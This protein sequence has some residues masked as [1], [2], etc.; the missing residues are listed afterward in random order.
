ME[1][2]RVLVENING[3]RW[4]KV[5]NDNGTSA[6][7]TQTTSGE[8]NALEP[9][10]SVQQA[11]TGIILTGTVATQEE[12]DAMVVGAERVFGSPVDNQLVVNPEADDQPW[13]TD[14]TYALGATPPIS[15]GTLEAN[16]QSITITGEVAT[17]DDA[18]LVDSAMGTISIPVTNGITVSSGEAPVATDLTDAELA[19]VNNTSV[20][21]AMKAYEL[22]NTAKQQLDS[23]VPLLLKTD[24]TL[25]VRG[26]LSDPHKPENQD[27]DSKARAQSVADYLISKGVPASRII[28]EGR[29]VA[30]PIASNNTAEGRAANQRA[31]LAL[32]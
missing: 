4:A 25:T 32:S 28:V 8:E 24:K 30:D 23:I 12:A 6:D 7:P 16:S 3:V 29:G 17:D 19:Q 20:S 1:R 5:S 26:Y 11:A 22:D 13:V 21:F 27:R 14:L 2:A 10:A 18:A 15:G 9:T 31:T